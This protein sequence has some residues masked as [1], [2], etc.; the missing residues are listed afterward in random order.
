M[1]GGDDRTWLASRVARLTI[2]FDL[3]VQIALQ[4]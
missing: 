3:I 1:R 2:S 4:K